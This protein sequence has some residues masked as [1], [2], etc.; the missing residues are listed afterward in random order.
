MI[1]KGLVSIQVPVYNAMP[2]LKKTIQSLLD[3]S[4]ENW[5]CIIVNDGS[6]DDTQF[7]LNS[8]TD[9]RFKVI[10]LKQNRGRPFARQVALDNAQGEY[11]AMLDGDDFYSFD[12]LFDQVKYLD[13]NKDVD[14][15]SSQMFSFGYSKNYY[16]VRPLE[17][18]C[19]K[20]IK[21][22]GSELVCAH[23]PSMFRHSLVGGHKYNQ[24]LKLGQDMDFLK[25]I[26]LNKCYYIIPKIHYY[27]TELDSVSTV[28]I[29]KTYNYKIQEVKKQK[30]HMVLCV[31]F[32]RKIL[33]RILS[34]FWGADFLLKIRGRKATQDEICTFKQHIEIYERN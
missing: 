2:H 19:S 21:Y 1:K 15:V 4:Y 25:R 27:Y 8:L 34:F 3:Q 23:G 6:T 17:K 5:E 26:M 18:V 33:I 9:H 16:R 28:K 22:T 31:F 11:I 12:K 13:K 30:K 20:K 29:Q 10:D 14:L 32:I 24:H 7:F